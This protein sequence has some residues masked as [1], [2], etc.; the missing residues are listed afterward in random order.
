[1]LV[2]PQKNTKIAK[3]RVENMRCSLCF[4]A[5]FCGKNTF[6]SAA[7]F[8]LPEC[9]FAAQPR[10][11][12]SSRFKPAG[13]Q[14]PLYCAGHLGGLYVGAYSAVCPTPFLPFVLH[15][16][17]YFTDIEA[18]GFGWIIE[19]GALQRLRGGEVGRRAG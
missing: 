6:L 18:Q 8:M 12:L 4:F 9:L 16:F 5:F 2:L 11:G 15:G 13:A 10:G 7:N 3:T 19:P 17:T 14:P 1:M